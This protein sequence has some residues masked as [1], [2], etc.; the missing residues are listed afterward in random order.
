MKRIGKVLAIALFATAVWTSSANA[1]PV[2]FTNCKVE[3]AGLAAPNVVVLKLSDNAA[4]PGFPTQFYVSFSNVANQMLAVALT[5]MASDLP[6]QCELDLALTPARIRKL[7][8]R[9]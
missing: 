4:T 5:A 2:F 3:A 1:E 8:L 6:T 9:L 7:N